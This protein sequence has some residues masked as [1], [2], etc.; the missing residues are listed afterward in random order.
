M[1]VGIPPP[2]PTGLP[3]LV[4]GFSGTTEEVERELILFSDS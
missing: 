4:V 1:A 3:A 2:R